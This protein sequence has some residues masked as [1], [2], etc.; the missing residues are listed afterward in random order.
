MLAVQEARNRT[1]QATHLK[2]VY[3]DATSNDCQVR[4][5]SRCGHACVRKVKDLA[6]VEPDFPLRE[7]DLGQTSVLDVSTQRRAGD[8]QNLHSPLRADQMTAYCGLLASS[9]DASSMRL[10]HG[11]V[12]GQDCSDHVDCCRFQ[13]ILLGVVLNLGTRGWSSSRTLRPAVLIMDCP[14]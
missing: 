6:L 3:L 4:F 11:F 1:P 13:C 12:T 10:I 8:S 5:K 7:L 9:D 14:L 2:S